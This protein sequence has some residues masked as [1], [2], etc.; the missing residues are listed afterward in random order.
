MNERRPFPSYDNIS[1]AEQPGM[2]EHRE[3]CGLDSGEKGVA[4]E[5]IIETR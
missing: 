4:L 5:K 3:F 1:T 2:V